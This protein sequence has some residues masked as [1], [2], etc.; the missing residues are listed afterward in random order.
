MDRTIE[1]G[2]KGNVFDGIDKIFRIGGFG[3]DALKAEV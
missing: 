2:G 3:R 1:G